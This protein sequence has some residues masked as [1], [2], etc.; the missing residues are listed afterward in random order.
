MLKWESKASVKSHGRLDLKR[1]RTLR[2]EVN[3]ALSTGASGSPK[4]PLALM[5]VDAW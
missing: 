5:A 1:R 3:M 2:N 4:E